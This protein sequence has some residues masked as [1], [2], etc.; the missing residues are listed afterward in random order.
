MV[1]WEGRLRLEAGMETETGRGKS[2]YGNL[3]YSF[4]EEP[5]PGTVSGNETYGKA[6]VKTLFT[7]LQ[8][9]WIAV[10][11]S[12]AAAILVRHGRWMK[13]YRASLP[14]D[15][16]KTDGYAEWRANHRWFRPV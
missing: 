4:T 8:T 15:A 10:S 13:K 6:D 7:L 9:V 3:T 5:V 11:L 1:L 16:V 14:G 12:L 2:S